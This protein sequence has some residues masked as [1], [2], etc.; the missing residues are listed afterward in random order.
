VGFGED[1]GKKVIK[2]KKK[3]EQEQEETAWDKY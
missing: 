2:D 1:I 3:R